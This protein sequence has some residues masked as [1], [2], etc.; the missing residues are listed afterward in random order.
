MRDDLAAARVLGQAL[1]LVG[2]L[3]DRLEV[4]LVLVLAPGRRDVGVPAL[5]HPAARELDGAL[6]ERRLQLEE[7]HGL[8]DVQ[9]LGHNHLR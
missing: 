4:A 9:E 5:R 1:E 6:V 2:R 8:L 7:Q 3:V